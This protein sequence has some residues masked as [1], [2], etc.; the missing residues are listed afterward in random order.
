MPFNNFKCT[1]SSSRIAQKNLEKLGS[2]KSSATR[3]NRVAEAASN[4][5]SEVSISSV[6]ISLFFIVEGSTSKIFFILGF[7]TSFPSIFKALLIN[8]KC[9]EESSR[10]F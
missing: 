8:A 10:S 1:F 2:G 6:D 4:S 5:S 3:A 9:L 7:G